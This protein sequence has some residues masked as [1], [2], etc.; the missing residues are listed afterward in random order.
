MNDDTTT[1]ARWPWLAAGALGAA[2]LWRGL[3]RA[4]NGKL[5][6]E[7]EQ[8]GTAFITGASSGIGATYARQLAA[9]GYDLIITARREEKLAAL[10][11][12]LRA[13]HGVAVRVVPADLS[14]PADI[15][16]LEEL[17]AEQT[18]LDF[19]IN[20]AGFGVRGRLGDTDVEKQ[21]AM[22]N[23]HV[24]STY[25]LSH[26]AVPGMIARGRGAIISVS[27]IAGF[28]SNPGA[29]NYSATKAYINTFSEALAGELRP[30]GIQVQA[31]C[32]GFTYSEFHDTPEYDSFSRSAFPSFMWADAEEVVADSLAAL[33]SGPVVFVPGFINKVLAQTTRSRTARIIIGVAREWFK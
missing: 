2:L 11:A 15:R 6:G 3:A 16:R 19:L 7:G 14:V 17:I 18:A 29:V 8:P 12:E 10:A 25:R 22:I 32:P 9:R 4:G 31:L 24:T 30:H 5:P 1:S 27:S 20:N 28:M 33:G 23:V 13:A 26:A 21:T